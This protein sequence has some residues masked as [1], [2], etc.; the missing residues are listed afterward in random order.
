MRQAC[1]RFTGFLYFIA[2]RGL[3]ST[4]DFCAKLSLQNK[5]YFLKSQRQGGRMWNKPTAEQLAAVPRLYETEHIATDDKIIYLH[6]FIGGC[7]WYI[8]EFDGEDL[9][10][11]YVNLNDPQNAEWGYISFRELDAINLD[12]L[13]VDNDLFWQP[14]AFSAINRP[15]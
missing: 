4:P 9:F 8:A 7:D 5:S 10:F 13:E 14:K 15:Q 3:L 11:G 1:F 2:F 12:G 6:F